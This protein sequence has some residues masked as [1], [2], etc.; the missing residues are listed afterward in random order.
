MGWH[1]KDED[2]AETKDEDEDKD[3]ALFMVI[4]CNFGICAIIHTLLVVFP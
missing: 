2:E 4:I 1:Y 3:E